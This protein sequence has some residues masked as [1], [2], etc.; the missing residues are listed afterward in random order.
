MPYSF[1][2]AKKANDEATKET[3]TTEEEKRS[4][5]I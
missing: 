2:S 5:M 1:A 4:S 3:N